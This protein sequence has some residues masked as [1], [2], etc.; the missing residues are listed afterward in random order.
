MIFDRWH[1][2]AFFL[3][4]VLLGFLEQLRVLL[5]PPVEDVPF[6]VGTRVLENFPQK[7]G[8]PWE[9]WPGFCSL[10]DPS[11]GPLLHKSICFRCFLP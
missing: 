6:C 8:L 11:L 2:K 1:F 3:L 5:E 9:C 4:D 7:I 10:G